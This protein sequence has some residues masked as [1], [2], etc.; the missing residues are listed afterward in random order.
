MVGCAELDKIRA[1]LASGL[2]LWPHPCVTVGTEVRVRDGIF[3][4]T[5]GV[6]TEFRQQCRVIIA[7]SAVRQCFSLEVEIDDL[8]VLNKPVLKA[9]L[10]PIPAYRYSLSRNI[11]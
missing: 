5:E 6:V 3:A 11:A 4:G 10:R 2:L 7:L 9:G 1:G 8:E